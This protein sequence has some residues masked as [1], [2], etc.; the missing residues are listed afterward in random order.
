MYQYPDYLMH[1]G[2]LGMKWGRRKARLSKKETRKIRRLD[3]KDEKYIRR[4]LAGFD[5]GSAYSQKK[6]GKEIKARDD[7][8]S[9]FMVTKN[10]KYYKAYQK[11]TADVLTKLTSDI[12]LPSGRKMEYVA[13]YIGKEGKKPY[14]FVER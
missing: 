1:Y 7:A 6:A 12:E 10:Q 5:L 13:D 3:K 8:W 11:A 2:I 9:A 4:N 14:K